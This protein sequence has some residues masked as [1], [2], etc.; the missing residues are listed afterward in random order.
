MPVTWHT[1]GEID[2]CQKMKKE[3]DPMLIEEL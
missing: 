1:S 2:A 3:R